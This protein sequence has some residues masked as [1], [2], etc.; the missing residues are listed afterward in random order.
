M[1]SPQNPLKPAAGMAE[2]DDRL[3]SALAVA[4]HPRIHISDFER[5]IGETY[6]AKTLAALKIA[7]PT[8][9][10]V[11]LMGADN[12]IQ[13]PSWHRWED[14]MQMVPI[15]VFN[16]P[17]YT[18]PA[19]NGLVARKYRKNRILGESG[20]RSF[21][22]LPGATAPIWAFVAQTTH[23]LSSSAIRNFDDRAGNACP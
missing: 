3:A 22:S 13:F 7:Y 6:T 14:I 21:R 10:F 9:K 2:Y 20:G 12:L 19:L 23:K 15:A 5:K 4:R 11:W 1:V 8:H 17:G 16:R 18:Y